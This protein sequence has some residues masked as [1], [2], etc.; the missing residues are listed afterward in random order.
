MVE[1]QIEGM[2]KL[3]QKLG[4][5][6]AVDILRKPMQRSLY[7]L[8]NY[9]ADYSL[10]SKKLPD[11]RT[12]TLSR[13][14]TTAIEHVTSTGSGLRGEIGN[15]TKYAPFVQS[16]QFQNVKAHA[17]YWQTDQMAYDVNKNDIVYIFEADIQL[18]LD[19]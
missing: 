18:E 5:A 8:Q 12:G 15:N 11:R 7:L 4:V 14:W 9:M 16:S 13:R 2:G 17:G 10:L 3:I 1:I 6:G 19:R